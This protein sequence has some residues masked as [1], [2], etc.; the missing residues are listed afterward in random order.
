MAVEIDPNYALSVNRGT[1]RE[2]R[3][4]DFYAARI[5]QDRQ[6]SDISL[7]LP[8]GRP[9]EKFRRL[10]ERVAARHALQGILWEKILEARRLR[11]SRAKFLAEIERRPVEGD[12]QVA[13]ERAELL[14]LQTDLDRLLERSREKWARE[15]PEVA[16]L[17][18]ARD[19]VLDHRSAILAHETGAETLA[20]NATQ[21]LDAARGEI[22]SIAER[23]R[24][25]EFKPYPARWIKDGARR[26]VEALAEKGRPDVF[27]AIDSGLDIALPEAGRSRVGEENSR[28]N[29]L[30][31][32]ASQR[33]VS[34]RRSSA[35]LTRTRAMKTRSIRKSARPCASSFRMNFWRPS[36]A[37]KQRSSRSRRTVARSSAARIW[38][39]APFWK[40]AAQRRNGSE[41]GSA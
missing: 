10:E 21:A 7:H 12:G 14:R 2:A 5:E 25:I 37:R 18:R 30:A 24:E 23:L 6:T 1:E 40:S 11:D 22:L 36:V 13:A 34:R 28:R 27:P 20:P 9:R 3:S 15:E 41:R 17:A 4:T 29:R 31:G 8:A 38:T 26:M 39:C 35:R 32:L 19:Y 16:L 33:C